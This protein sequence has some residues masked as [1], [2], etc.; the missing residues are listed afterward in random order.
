M[1]PLPLPLALLLLLP[2]GSEPAKAYSAKGPGTWPWQA[3]IFLD[4][5]YRCEGALISP[6]WVLT[7]ANCFGSWPRSHFTVTL[8]PDRL[9][10]D[11]C[12]GKSGVEELLLPARGPQGSG[13]RGLALARLARPPS[14]SSAVR[15]IPLAVRSQSFFPWKLCWAQGF[16]PDF[17]PYILP[18]ELREV[19]LRPLH[20]SSCRAHFLL[21]PHCADLKDSLPK[22]SQCARPP[23]GPPDL[24]TS[25]AAGEK[26][27]TEPK[28]FVGE[29][30]Y[31][32]RDGVQGGGSATASGEGARACLCS[33]GGTWAPAI[34]LPGL[35]QLQEPW[36]LLT[37]QG[38]P[39]AQ[40]GL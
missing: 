12:E 19:P 40:S 27:W 33:A 13:L 31:L 34:S 21:H 4:S 9:Q 3:S 28:E 39:A 2:S 7:G 11:T 18:Q 30:V 37:K 10:L 22:G 36:A 26:N 23:A 35:S 16:E 29:R 15:P 17:D 6:E 8:G 1:L 32:G 24:M 25:K 14:L 20:L 38:L 5:R